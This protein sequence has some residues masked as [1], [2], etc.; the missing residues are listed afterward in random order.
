L[1]NILDV[2]G[3]EELAR[4]KGPELDGVVVRSANKESIVG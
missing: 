2:K 3:S 1:I 4:C